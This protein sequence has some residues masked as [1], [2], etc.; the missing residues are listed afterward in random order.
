MVQRE[1]NS[2][3]ERN[4]KAAGLLAAIV[5]VLFVLWLVIKVLTYFFGTTTVVA[6]IESKQWTRTVHIQQYLWTSET[7][8][9]YPRGDFRNLYTTQSCVRHYNGYKSSYSGTTCSTTYHYQI[10]EWR[11]TRNVGVTATQDASHTYVEPYWPQYTL[12]T[13]TDQPERFGGQTETYTLHFLTEDRKKQ[14]S[15]DLQRFSWQ[16]VSL[17]TGYTLQIDVMGQIRHYKMN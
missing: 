9:W 3:L 12:Q 5:G 16:P 1:W 14:Y 6:Q 8:F 2:S 11:D 13:N 10:R 17:G 15:V 7:S 4:K